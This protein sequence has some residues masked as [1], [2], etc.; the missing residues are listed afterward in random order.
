MLVRI[1]KVQGI[2][3][4]HDARGS[5]YKLGRFA[6]LYGGNGRGKSTLASV[7]RSS[8]TGDSTTLEERVT[9]DAG[10]SPSV[11]LQF[12][13]GHKVTYD[14]KAWTE[15]RSEFIVYDAEF[16]NRNV[17]SGT[18]ITPD[19]R[20]N[21]LDFALGDSAVAARS[22]EE[23]ASLAQQRASMKIRDLTARL[24]VYAVASTVAVFRSLRP[25]EQPDAKRKAITERLSAATR[26]ET[27]LQQPLPAETPEPTLDIGAVFKVLN[28]T[29][30]DIQLEAEAAV[31]AHVQTVGLSE[32]T[33]WISEGQQFDN[34]EICPYCGQGTQGL[35]L[36]RMYQSH[37]NR[38]YQD[39]RLAIQACIKG[40]L[41]STDPALFE[42]IVA[43]RKQTNERLT[44]W[45]PYVDLSLLTEERDELSATSLNNLRELLL[46]LLARKA[47]APS[48][49]IATVE[50]EDDAQRLWGQF[51]QVVTETNELIVAQRTTI[52]IFQDSLRGQEPEL[53]ASELKQLDLAIL[54][55]TPEVVQLVDELVTAEASLK[56]AEQSKKTARTALTALMTATLS[57]YRT[58]IN[59]HLASLGA[60]FAIDEIKTNYMG[61]APRTDYGITLRGT[62]IKLAGGLPSFATALSEGDKRSMAF[63]FFVA[64]TL[65]DPQLDQKI[66][67]IDDPVSSLDK[68]RREY[69][70]EILVRIAKQCGQLI[71]LAHDAVF[72]RDLRRALVKAR[73]DGDIT[74]MQI[75]RAPGDYSDFG[76]V[77]LDRECESAYYTNY[78]TVTDFVAGTTTD[79]L[80][81]AKAMRPLLEGYLHRR[82]PGKISDGVMLGTAIEQ[83]DQASPP[84]PLVH[85]QPDVAEMRSLNDFAGRF[86]HDTNPDS[87]SESPD[88]QSV[89]AYGRRVLDLVHGA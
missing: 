8:A 39:L 60:Y 82:Y 55:H 31:E 63:A 57:K 35:S 44:A 13:G 47:L 3:L 84:S 65:A 45:K 85:A 17:Y 52:G 59:T 76:P 68:A 67:V 80:T 61:S 10:H 18:E 89:L 88:E 87:A 22:T 4:L 38:A 27:I 9:V 41:Q 66:V 77:D 43:H 6:L 86:H 71:V 53:I 56:D 54:R 83:V 20:K 29:L 74:N 19:H 46:S 40:V 21:L 62:P 15:Q 24:Q 28:Q 2:G 7:F 25:V 11:I 32:V 42:E 50:E 5:A 23:Q 26:A 14:A 78:R 69:T 81:A 79:R 37:F 72:L 49:Q 64:S 48:D 33:A 34:H 51:L 12:D 16:V 70:T 30:D 75:A 1:E 58:D 73:I 36:I